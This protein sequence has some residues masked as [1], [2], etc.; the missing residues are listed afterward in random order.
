M[1]ATNRALQAYC[2]LDNSFAAQREYQLLVD[3]AQAV[4]KGDQEM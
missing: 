2:E 4:E 1:V 3:L